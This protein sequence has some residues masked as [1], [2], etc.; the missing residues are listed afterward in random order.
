MF[1]SIISPQKKPHIAAPVASILQD[2]PMRPCKKIDRQS[3]H[4]GLNIDTFF[5]EL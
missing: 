4:A 3:W 1:A 2:N 5:R